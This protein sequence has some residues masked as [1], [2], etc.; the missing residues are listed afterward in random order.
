MPLTVVL[1]TLE[2]EKSRARRCCPGGFGSDEKSLAGSDSRS[3]LASSRIES[4]SSF[5]RLKRVLRKRGQP[6]TGVMMR[7]RLLLC[8]LYHPLDLLVL[9]AETSQVDLGTVLHPLA[10]ITTLS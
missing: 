6:R 4:I 8:V 1:L 3:L 9:W 10:D 2:A 5:G 7:D